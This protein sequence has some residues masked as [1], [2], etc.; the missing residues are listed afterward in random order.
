MAT[1]KRGQ[2]VGAIDLL[3]LAL[4]AF[5]RRVRVE[6][7]CFTAVPESPEYRVIRRYAY[8]L[9]GAHVRSQQVLPAA[10]SRN[11][12]EFVVRVTRNHL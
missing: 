11:E 12:H 7:I 3:L 9:F 2:H 5:V 4:R 10:I 1:S 6:R 8:T